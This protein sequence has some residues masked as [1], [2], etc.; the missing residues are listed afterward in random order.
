MRREAAATATAAPRAGASAAR[1]PSIALP[2]L[3]AAGLMPALRLGAV[4]DPAE[5]EADR[6]AD[7]VMAGRP[8]PPAHAAPALRRACA[9]CADED[10]PVRRR[11]AGAGV[12]PAAAASA[13][14]AAAIA[15]TVG[16]GAPLP[17][18]ERAFF[19]PRLGRDLSG[20]RVHTGGAA[21][22]GAAAIDALAYTV[23]HDV[24]FGAGQ[25]RPGD[26]G[27]R[28]LLAH[29]LAHVAQGG[30]AVV[31]RA[32]L[33][34]STTWTIPPLARPFASTDQA[35]DKATKLAAELATQ[36]AA[37]NARLAGKPPDLTAVAVDPAN[38]AG[39]GTEAEVWLWYL[40]ER[41]A[42][43]DRR[44][45]QVDLVTQ[46]GWTGSPQAQ[47]SLT[48]DDVGNASIAIV[49]SGK[50]PDSPQPIAAGTDAADT[51]AKT[52]SFLTTTY[53]LKDVSEDGATWTQ[54]HLNHVAAAFTM[55]PAPVVAALKDVDLKRVA[56]L[57]D[58]A[59][60]FSFN[61]SVSG[62]TVVDTA[63]LRLSDAIFADD[64][65]QFSG[66]AGVVVP[67]SVRR[68]VHEAGHAIATKALR[69]A[70][71]AQFRA[72]AATSAAVPPRDAAQ[73][74]LDAKITEFNSE[75]DKARR[76]ALKV[77]IDALRATH[78]ALEKVRVDA[79][80]DEKAKKSATG[81]VEAAGAAG[82]AR[83]KA[84]VDFVNKEKIAPFTPYAKD[85]WALKPEE[86]YAEAFSLWLAD[87][88]YL[89]THQKKVFDWFA[90]GKY[91]A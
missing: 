67:E 11:A 51:L 40:L 60:D 74:A 3:Y 77:E 50:V 33:Y 24:V 70:R 91:L 79:V 71:G 57:P 9:T 80:A 76:A 5:R 59:G 44:G 55:L 8:P 29:E 69:D 90:A 43:K 45:T 6:I 78:T 48:V 16:G 66:S 54:P 41:L 23:G 35:A 82:S 37:V 30:A 86:F 15:A 31:R 1:P 72:T 68:I 27:G 25:W 12:A 26:A 83:V 56:T 21:A 58:A 7:A 81:K 62:T 32:V 28:R 14:P 42:T 47:V 46:V 13:V 73:V 63:T 34:D 85:N 20:V 87:P 75:K 4:D 64:A 49:A 10:A 38:G 52:R 65:K 19:E 84:F 39:T 22:R 89:R 17:A 88:D 18:G 53:G 2:A 61:Q 36:R